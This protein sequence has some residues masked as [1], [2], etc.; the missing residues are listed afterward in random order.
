MRNSLAKKNKE[1]KA[2]VKKP[3]TKKTVMHFASPELEK[4]FNSMSP[5]CRKLLQ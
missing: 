5:E 1:K 4:L 2:S 3:S